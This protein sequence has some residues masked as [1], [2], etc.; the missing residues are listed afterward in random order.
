MVLGE[1]NVA[2]AKPNPDRSSPPVRE[3]TGTH[4]SSQRIPPPNSGS[5]LEVCLLPDGRRPPG[6]DC[7]GHRG[8]KM[9]FGE[10]NKEGSVDQI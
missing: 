1:M 7:I 8:W 4:P 2:R 9:I 3:G 5:R 6:P 10:D